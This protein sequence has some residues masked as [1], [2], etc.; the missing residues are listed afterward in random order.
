MKKT[1]LCPECCALRKN[2]EQERIKDLQIQK[3]EAIDRIRIYGE[4][5]EQQNG[6]PT[7][8]I[9]NVIGFFLGI[10]MLGNRVYDFT[11]CMKSY[12]R[13]ACFP[14]ADD[15]CAMS[16]TREEYEAVKKLAE[17]T[18]DEVIELIKDAVEYKPEKSV[19]E[20]EDK[21]V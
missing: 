13:N 17:M 8:I 14:G 12:Y 15:I 20:T 5:Y 2:C 21:V 11:S 10:K 9:Q 3:A 18:E 7:G 6:L 4:V 19:E 1:F 16:M